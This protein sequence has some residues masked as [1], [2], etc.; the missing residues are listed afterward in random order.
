MLKFPLLLWVYLFLLPVQLFF[1]SFIGVVYIMQFTLKVYNSA[2]FT[3]VCRYVPSIHV[4]NLGTFSHTR[5][6]LYSLA[7]LSC[8]PHTQPKQLINCFLYK[9]MDFCVPIFWVGRKQS[10][11][12]RF[13]GFG[14][15]FCF[16]S[17]LLV[18]LGWKCLQSPVWGIWEAIRKPG[19]PLLCCFSSPRVPDCL[20]FILSFIVFQCLL[21]VLFYL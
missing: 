19:I 18:V 9:L 2:V 5:R 20:F 8:H 4:N 11:S 15:L 13:G 7:V 6:M 3:I 21:V 17:C 12:W 10:F 14:F 16:C 1:N